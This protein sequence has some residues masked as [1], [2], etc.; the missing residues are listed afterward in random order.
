MMLNVSSPLFTLK[1]SCDVALDAS[2]SK[3][4]KNLQID[5]KNLILSMTYRQIFC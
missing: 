3:L 2:G 5:V 4:V 1:L